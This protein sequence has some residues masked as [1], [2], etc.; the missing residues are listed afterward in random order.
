MARD[1]NAVSVDQGLMTSPN[2]FL[3][4]CLDYTGLEGIC[5]AGQSLLSS[6]NRKQ[7]NRLG[8]NSSWVD[9]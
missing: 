1:P 7:K 5:Q 2:R 9:E 8:R 3:D 6:E 4:V